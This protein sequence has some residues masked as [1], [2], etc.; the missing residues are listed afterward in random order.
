MLYEN[1][2]HGQGESITLKLIELA[3]DGELRAMRMCMERLLPAAKA[4]D[5]KAASFRSRRSA[6]NSTSQ[7]VGTASRAI[8]GA[9]LIPTDSTRSTSLVDHDSGGSLSPVRI[10]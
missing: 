9:A 7:P 6:M 2:L 10:R 4:G 8:P 5:H 3:N 1:L